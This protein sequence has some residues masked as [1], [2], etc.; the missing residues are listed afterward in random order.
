ML[1]R[2]ASRQPISS[3]LR[4]TSTRRNPFVVCSKTFTT[5]ETMTNARTAREWS[6]A[7]L[8]GRGGIAKHFVAVSTTAAGVSGFGIET[9]NMFSFWDEP[10]TNVQHSFYRHTFGEPSGFTGG[11]LR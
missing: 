8:G 10:G 2:W 1:A 7:T 5:L 6:L 9:E 4:A 11:R 3:R